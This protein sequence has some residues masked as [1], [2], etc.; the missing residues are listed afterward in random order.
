MTREEQIQFCEKCLKRK[1]DINQGLVCEL[2]G[3]IAEFAYSCSNFSLDNS[4]VLNEQEYDYV[5]LGKDKLKTTPEIAEKLKL[6]QNLPLGILGGIVAGIIA[7]FLWIYLSLLFKVQIGYFAIGVGI[8]IG[9]AIRFFGKGLDKI[10][11]ICGAIISLVCCLLGNFLI[12]IISVAETAEMGELLMILKEI[13]YNYLPEIMI[14]TFHPMD[15]VFYVLAM[16]SGYSF[17]FRRLTK[18]LI[19]KYGIR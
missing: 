1:M 14:E 19:E 13:D 10:F 12:L 11:G 17:S 9:F 7:C 15:L 4:V 2:T 16:V 8:V 5:K 3:K 6:Q 18:E